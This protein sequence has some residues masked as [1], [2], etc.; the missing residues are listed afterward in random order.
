MQ[1]A[2]YADAEIISDI[3]SEKYLDRAIAHIYKTYYGLLENLVLQNS[4]NQADAEDVIQ[5]V[6]LVFVE[7]VQKE[8]Y[9]G[10]ASIKSFLYTLTRN[11]WISELRKRGSASRRHESYEN[12]K[13]NS[14]ADVSEYLA[15]KEGQQFIQKLFAQLGDKCQ[16]ILTLFY[17]GD[18]SMKEILQK[19]DYDNEQV[20][21]N[22][23]Y[24]C[25]KSLISQVEQSPGIYNQLKNALHHAK[26]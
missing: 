24:K 6:L 5:E 16:Q 1:T 15:Y 23:K 22:K 3:Q 18:Y 21:R 14:E 10:K 26:W 13:E 20:L 11:M 8:K 4:G 7:M 25:L 9:Q 2:S 17:Y 12:E 19:T